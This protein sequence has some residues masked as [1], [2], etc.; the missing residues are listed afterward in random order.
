MLNEN[1]TNEDDLFPD[2]FDSEMPHNQV[3]ETEG[4]EE[5]YRVNID[6][7]THLRTSLL[8]NISGVVL[9][10]LI[11]SKFQLPEFKTE[12]EE[13]EGVLYKDLQDLTS[14]SREWST[15]KSEKTII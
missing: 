3:P 1:V 11:Q 2:P 8:T 9:Q 7:E 5:V 4:T 14:L 13:D 12:V 15:R 10:P 6:E